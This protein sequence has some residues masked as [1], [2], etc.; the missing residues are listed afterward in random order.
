[1]APK[2]RKSTRSAAAEKQYA[3][4]GSRYVVVKHDAAF[5]EGLIRGVILLGSAVVAAMMTHPMT[6]WK[7]RRLLKCKRNLPRYR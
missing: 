3:E 5:A 1:M 2:R 7:K 4:D 6:R